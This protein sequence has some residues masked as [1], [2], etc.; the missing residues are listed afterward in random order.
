MVLGSIF[1]K[2]IFKCC[3][4]EIFRFDIIKESTLNKDVFN[5][6]RTFI[7]VLVLLCRKYNGL[8]NLYGRFGY[9]LIHVLHLLYVAGGCN[10]FF[11]S[12]Q[13]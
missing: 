10:I 11:Y 8:L 3:N 7:L 2:K 1:S 5:G 9:G 12:I 13:V 4:S 6:E